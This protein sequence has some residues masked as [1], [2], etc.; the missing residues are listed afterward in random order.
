MGRD[1]PYARATWPSTSTQMPLLQSIPLPGICPEH[2]QGEAMPSSPL[3]L[4]VPRPAPQSFLGSRCYTL[5]LGSLLG[6]IVLFRGC[7]LSSVS[8]GIQL[9]PGGSSQIRTNMAMKQF[10]SG[11]K[12]RL[13]RFTKGSACAFSSNWQK[14]DIS[15]T[16]FSGQLLGFC[17]APAN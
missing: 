4:G 7:C 5:F 9:R 1:P 14:Q 2:D 8:L 11:E 12:K 17:S 16:A 15:L 10:P 6:V 3:A 13:I